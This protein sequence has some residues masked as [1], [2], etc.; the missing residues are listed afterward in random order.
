M[1]TSRRS[2][3]K[4]KLVLLTFSLLSVVSLYA[5]SDT[6]L[7]LWYNQ[8]AKQWVEALPMGN[9]RLGAMVFGSP[10]QEEIQLN[11]IT[12][13]AGQPNR[14]DNP[15][16]KEA[17]PKVRQLIFNGQYKE[18]QDLVNQKFISRISQGMPYQTAGNLYLAF[19]GHENFK[20]YYREL[21]IETADKHHLFNS[22]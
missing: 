6:S 8:P 17:L 13:L 20:N 3:I 16:A 19:P 14:N 1:E 10:S 18:A 9:G 5:Q 2:F 12:V 11:E 21:N 7:K 4:T 15:D 22:D